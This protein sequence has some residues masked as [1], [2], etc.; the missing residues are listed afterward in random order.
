M[1]NR[2]TFIAPAEMITAE[3]PSPSHRQAKTGTPE[4]FKENVTGGM[5]SRLRQ[6]ADKRDTMILEEQARAAELPAAE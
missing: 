3:A 2:G 5:L 1:Q 4:G 6:V